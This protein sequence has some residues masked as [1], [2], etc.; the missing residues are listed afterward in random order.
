M[1]ELV[2]FDWDG[3][4]ANSIGQLT[5]TIRGAIRAAGLPA[6][7]P[8]DIRAVIGLGELGGLARLY[9]DNPEAARQVLIAAQSDHEVRALADRPAALF[10]G[11]R[12][13]LAQLADA[14]CLLAVATAKGRAGLLN[15]LAAAGIEHCF[16]A[17]A[18]A[19]DGPA[20][21]AP[22][23]LENLLAVTG[24]RGRD[25]V[26]VGDTLHDL[27]MAAAAG[28]PAVGVSW[29]VHSRGELARAAPAAVVDSLDDLSA[30]LLGG[31][32]PPKR[33]E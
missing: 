15:D 7:H 18:T 27:R 14:G 10:P 6:R 31:P 2:V 16:A 23:I 22:V 12:A 1:A 25:A 17:L 32:D 11:T 3:T 20:K 9:P 4:L 19:D 5:E 29:G 8:D 30:H 26:M 33:A 21:P 28:V 13:L 24:T